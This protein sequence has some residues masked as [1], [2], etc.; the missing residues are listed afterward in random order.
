[1][2]FESLIWLIT[3]LSDFFIIFLLLCLAFISA[4]SRRE[5]HVFG[6]GLPIYWQSNMRLLSITTKFD[7]IEF[8]CHSE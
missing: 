5:I 1:M 6:I 2:H 3:L 7:D 8:Q 4:R